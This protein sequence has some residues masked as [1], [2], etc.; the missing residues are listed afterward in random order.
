MR[1]IGRKESKRL[2]DYQFNILADLLASAKDREEL[3]AICH[4][5][6][7]PSEREAIAQRVA[8]WYEIRG[9]STYCEIEGKYGV[10]PTTISKA[11]D[12]YVKH[13]QYN[14]KFNDVAKRYKPPLFREFIKE[15]NPDLINMAQFSGGFR[16]LLRDNQ[17]NNSNK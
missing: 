8:I 6:L 15:D 12:V 13:G 4:I 11:L 2:R 5:I 10:S 7:T 17:Q 9:G 14:E 3:A 1:K 16:Q